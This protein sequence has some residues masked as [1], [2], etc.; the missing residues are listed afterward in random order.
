VSPG[1]KRRPRDGPENTR[2]RGS[3]IE[4]PKGHWPL[5]RP[6]ILTIVESFSS[7]AP[8]DLFRGPVK[9]LASVSPSHSARRRDNARE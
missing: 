3:R 1:R 2:I 6:G 4:L 5:A 9:G 8:H 7:L